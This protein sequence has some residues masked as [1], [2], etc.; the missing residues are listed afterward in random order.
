MANKAVICPRHSSHN[1]MCLID[2][3]N[4]PDTLDPGTL[5][6]FLFKGGTDTNSSGASD[7]C[8]LSCADEKCDA[9]GVRSP[10]PNQ[11]QTNRMTSP[12]CSRLDEPST[13]RTR[14]G[15]CSSACGALPLRRHRTNAN[16][17]PRASPISVVFLFID[18]L[19][20]LLNLTPTS[21]HASHDLH[22][23]YYQ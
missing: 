5:P 3:S 8:K 12:R 11:Q 18:S 7:L 4:T 17:K 15:E 10:T 16:T 13:A 23:Q 22:L 9:G 21:H 14:T 19:P 2:P 20:T 1:P 6:A